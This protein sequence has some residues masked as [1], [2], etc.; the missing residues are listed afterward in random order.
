MHIFVYITNIHIRIHCVFIHLVY[1]Y[2][3]GR[4]LEQ[5]R[6]MH[7]SHIRVMSRMGHVSYESCH[8][9]V[10]SHMRHVTYV[11]G[12]IWVISYISHV[13][14]H[15]WVMSHVT[16]ESSLIWVKSN[17]KSCHTSHMSHVTYESSQ[18]WSHVT[19]HTWVT[20]HMSQVKY[21]VM[22]HVT[23]ES[24]HIWVKSHMS[25][26][27]CHTWVVS[28]MSQVTHESCHIWVKWHMSHFTC[29]ACHL[30]TSVSTLRHIYVYR[31]MCISD[32]MHDTITYSH[33][34][35]KCLQLLREMPVS[36]I[37]VTSRMS[38]PKYESCHL[39]TP[40]HNHTITYSHN[41]SKCL[42]QLQKMRGVCQICV[43]S[44]VNHVPYD[45]CPIWFMPKWVMSL[46]HIIAWLHIHI[47]I[48]CRQVPGAA[49][50]D[51]CVS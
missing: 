10:M 25:H 9:W 36:H 22:S 2:H 15:I 19:C 28:R 16:Y 6:E 49:A 12:H 1:T 34:A 33:N 37:Y 46:N 4:C 23:H 13:T 3:V 32:I 17:M 24:C 21:E 35:G 31:H 30:D 42:E 48:Q 27:T 29:K 51:V 45:L 38:H 41:A 40:S 26:V 44:R 50:G 39:I 20:S 11:P 47:I 18:I 43:M 5:V 14:C 8:I 7:V